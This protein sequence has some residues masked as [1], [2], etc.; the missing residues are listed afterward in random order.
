MSTK[1]T[2]DKPFGWEDQQAS[3]GVDFYNPGHKHADALFDGMVAKNLQDVE[4]NGNQI[5][6]DHNN[7][8]SVRSGEIAPAMTPQTVRTRPVTNSEKANNRSF[9]QAV[10]KRLLTSKKL[11]GKGSLMT[12]LLLLFGG[13]SFLTVFFAPGLATINFK[14]LINQNLN[15]Q[16]HTID[17]R[18]SILIRSKLKDLTNGSCGAIKIQ[19]RFKTI[20]DAQVEKFKTAGIEIKTTPKEERKWFNGN[21]GQIL[22]MNYV[23]DDGVTTIKTAAELHDNLMNNVAFRSAMIKGFNPVY[24]SINDK[25]GLSVMK[26]L[27]ISKAVVIEGEND[28]ERQKRIDAAVSGIEDSNH[29]TVTIKKD[30]NGKELYYD[31][32]GNELTK[33]EYDAAKQQSE[34]IAEYS[35]NGGTSAVLKNAVKG[36]SIVGY[37]DSACTVYNAFRLVSGMAKIEREAQAARFATGMVLTPADA[38]K[39]GDISEGSA[40]FAGN[41]LMSTR[42]PGEVIDT[43]QINNPGSAGN[44]AKIADPEAGMNAMDGPGYRMMAYGEAPDLSPRAAQFMTGGGSVSMLDGVLQSVATVVNGGDPNPQAVSEK[45]GYIQNPVVRFSGLAIGIVAGIGSFGLSTAAGIAGSTAIALA[46]PYLESQA[47]DMLAGNTFKGIANV[48]AGD[49]AVVGSIALFGSIAKTRGLKPLSAKEAIAYT[50]AS[51][52]SRGRYIESQQYLARQTPLDINNPYSFV[53]S[54]AGTV[55]P[56]LQRSKNSASAAMMS[57]SNLIPTSFGSIVKPVGAAR[58]LDADYYKKCNDPGYHLLGLGADVFCGVHYGIDEDD[59]KIEPDEIVRFMVANDEIDIESEYGDAKDNGRDWNYVKYLKECPNRTVGW[60]ESDGENQGNGWNCIDPAK[61]AQNRYY[62]LYTIDKSVDA[63]LDAEPL[64]TGSDN[65]TDTA[66]N[67]NIQGWVFPTIPDAVITSG[68]ETNSRP[69]HHGVDIGS[70]AILGQPVYAA[71]DGRVVEM[72]RNEVYGDY[73]V[74][75]HT[76]DNKKLSTVYGNLQSSSILVHE[77]QL[78]KAGDTIAK[79]GRSTEGESPH[80]HFEVWEGSPMNNGKP[81]DPTLIIETTRRANGARNA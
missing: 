60:G 43:T 65:S 42:P 23:N 45:C 35:K 64:V 76:L 5:I 49:A 15:D 61:E 11:K 75:E 32:D 46:L 70:N 72:N 74:I 28:E 63:A 62:R 2:I 81:S 12:L 1:S 10:L 52:S 9:N 69:D 50:N 30:E 54:L 29:K 19:C 57:I 8:T 33:A 59:L 20:S 24:Y 44:P 6:A 48:D 25:I 51:Q 3:D 79:I 13:G 31:S 40:N 22:E 34:R 73:I 18:S 4:Q 67:S 71:R 16:L 39:A 41:T 14:E 17:E 38:S 68:Y 37:M 36:A 26:H 58:V 56:L 80:L 53:G 21:R 7:P 78:V 66:D 55:S 27:K 47:A 77:N